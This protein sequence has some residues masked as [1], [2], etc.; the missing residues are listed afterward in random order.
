V[1]KVEFQTSFWHSRI[2]I[3]KNFGL[4]FFLNKAKCHLHKSISGFQ[5]P[6]RSYGQNSKKMFENVKENVLSNSSLNFVHNFWLEAW[7][8]ELAWLFT[9]TWFKELGSKFFEK[10]VIQCS[11]EHWNSILNTIYAFDLTT[12]SWASTNH[13]LHISNRLFYL[14]P[15]YLYK[16]IVFSFSCIQN[17]WLLELRKIVAKYFDIFGIFKN[18][19]FKKVKKFVFIFFKCVTNV[20]KLLP[21]YRNIALVKKQKQKL[22]QRA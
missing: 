12:S 11:S 3:S 14:L 4:N 21:R 10:N 5:S 20:P 2:T 7:N 13:N 16:K 18:N 8:F 19:I 6:K 22:S 1:F 9:L 15:S 17:K